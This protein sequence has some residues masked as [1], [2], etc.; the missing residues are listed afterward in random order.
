VDNCIFCGEPFGPSRQRS[1]EHAAPKWC[2]EILPDRGQAEHKHVVE[3]AE[4]RDEQ[5]QGIRDPFTTVA[6]DICKPCNNGWMEELEDWAKRWLAKPITGQRRSLRYWRQALA[7]SWAI[8]TAMVWECV[9]PTDQMITA[10][11]LRIFHQL[12]RPSGNQQVWTARYS[13][14][15]PHS[16]R[17]TVAS[18]IGSRPEG[19]SDPDNPHAYLITLS[20]G[21]LAFVIFGYL[22]APPMPNVTLPQ[23]FASKLVQ[24]WP[25]ATEIVEWPPAHA[26]DD[27]DLDA[28]VRSLGAPIKGDLEAPQ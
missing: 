4:G 23:R 16:F 28:V 13:G 19:A 22:L 7:A 15:D 3:T 11:A 14:S 17:R 26:L 6:G 24:I 5:D 8:K 18:V 20:I 2:G 25:L 12:Q 10:G 9:S 21:E 1:D 27:A